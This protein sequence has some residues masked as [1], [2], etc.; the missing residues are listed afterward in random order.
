MLGFVCLAIWINMIDSTVVNVAL[1]AIGEDLHASNA[2]MQWVLDAFNVT[3]AGVVLLGSG[4]ADRYGRKL[5]LCIG[6]ALFTLSSIGVAFSDSAMELIV[7]RVVMG[8]GVALVMPASLAIIAVTF[9]GE[10]RK[11]AVAVWASVGGLGLALGPVLGGMLLN[12]FSWRS[13]FL[14]NVPFTLIAL[15]GVVVL[16]D[17]SRKPGLTNLDPIGGALSLAGLGGLVFALIEGPVLGWT[18]PAV[19]V[20]GVVGIVGLASFI[21]WEARHRNPM[22]DVRVLL[23]SAVAVGSTALFL[24]YWVVYALIYLLPQVFRY[25]DGMSFA[26]VGVALFPLGFIFGLGSQFSPATAR[27]FGV[28][29]VVGGGFLIMGV[30]L[31]GMALVLELSYWIVLV[32]I[33]LFCVGWSQMVAP[34]TAV[35]LEALPV[36]KAGDGSAVNLISRQAGAAVGVAVTG[37]MVSSIYGSRLAG[38]E[39]VSDEQ[40]KAAG[41]S[42]SEASRIASTLPPATGSDLMARAVDDFIRAATASILVNG[43]LAFLF[44]IVALWALRKFSDG[45]GADEA[46]EVGASGLAEAAYED[47]LP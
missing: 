43:I 45:G 30:T 3:V 38:I 13:V 6:L 36:A 7:V 16:A 31:V 28:R 12:W 47:G 1:P 44:G 42:L 9:T 35:V 15:I 37:C 34:A 39:G 32:M 26:V 17:E 5:I 2:D 24:T 8:L 4:M 22:F 20:A 18:S 10:S 46:D 11:T 25:G 14:V 41:R 19:V 27:R 33:I 40:L 23:V 29:R 21:I